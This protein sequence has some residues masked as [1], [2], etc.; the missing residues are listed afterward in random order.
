[1]TV[2]Q[3]YRQ[4]GTDLKT[5]LEIFQRLRKRWLAPYG[6]ILL[7]LLPVLLD[8][9]LRDSGTRARP[10][11]GDRVVIN[12]GVLPPLALGQLGNAHPCLVAFPWRVMVTL[13]WREHV[14]KV[15]L[16]G[17]FGLKWKQNKQ[18]AILFQ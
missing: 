4:S 15:H 3:A 8:L 13:R 11:G 6:F 10:L 1:M 12:G 2:A 5:Y 9:A 17:A 14:T 7:L 16:L 18:L